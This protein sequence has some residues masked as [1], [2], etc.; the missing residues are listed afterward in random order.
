LLANSTW[1]WLIEK[2]L[3][4]E[5][6]H[7]RSLLVLAE[8]LH[9]GRAAD[10]LGIAQPALSRQ[11]QQLEEEL[12]TQLFKRSPRAVALTDAGHEFVEGIGPAIQQI[13]D[14]AAGATILLGL[15]EEGF[16]SVLLAICPP[17]SSRTCC[18]GFIRN[19]RW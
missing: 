5:L 14:A 4:M 17:I 11:I 18:T 2:Q 9:F 16:V 13:E 10:R 12:Q 3:I 15:N 19:R 1:R 6:R 7:L 8:E